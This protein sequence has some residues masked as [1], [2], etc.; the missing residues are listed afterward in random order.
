M[1]KNLTKKQNI[2]FTINPKIRFGKPTVPGT[3]IAIEDILRLV[4]AGYSIAEIP[5]EYPKVNLNQAR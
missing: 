1:K 4:E 2:Q 5:N 3:R